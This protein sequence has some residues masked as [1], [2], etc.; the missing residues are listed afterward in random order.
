MS[1]FPKYAQL[2]QQKAWGVKVQRLKLK[3]QLEIN[4][5][6]RSKESTERKLC[7]FPKT[8]LLVSSYREEPEG[9][10]QNKNKT[11]KTIEVERNRK[12]Q[13]V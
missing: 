9:S 13:E 12:G 8:Q 11:K 4:S 1:V 7:I 10:G 3:E 6:P 2:G 5:V